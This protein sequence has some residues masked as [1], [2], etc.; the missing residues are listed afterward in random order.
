MLLIHCALPKIK[1]WL[2]ENWHDM[3]TISFLQYSGHGFLQAPYIPAE[4][5]EIEAE[6]LKVKPITSI[7]CYDDINELEIQIKE[8][9]GGSFCPVK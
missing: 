2:V 5:E 7:L 4:K 1:E 3:K 8:C 6:L 9:E